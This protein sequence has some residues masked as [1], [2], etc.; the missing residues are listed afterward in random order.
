[1]LAAA[2]VVG[3]KKPPA[4]P[5]AA[6][7]TPPVARAGATP[8]PPASAET[9]EPAPSSDEAPGPDP[10]SDAAPT[11]DAAGT[12]PAE[13]ACDA[14]RARI[15]D[16]IDANRS[17]EIDKDCVE[18]HLHCFAPCKDAVHGDA[19]VSILASATAYFDACGQGGCGKP[20]C[21]QTSAPVCDEGRCTMA[22]R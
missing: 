12:E 21:A 2:L 19:R 9:P 13:S 1:M 16:S 10:T 14:R 18:I 4:E 11:E 5:P 17:C 3:C 22:P 8:E 7:T 6:L 15:A 20:T